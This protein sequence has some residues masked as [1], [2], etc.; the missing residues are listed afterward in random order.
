MGKNIAYGA[1]FGVFWGIIEGI[2][3]TLLHRIHLPFTGEILAS[4]AILI[5]TFAYLKS[6]KKEVV[7]IAG[8]IA[9][10]TKL[11]FMGNIF[12]GPIIG[13]GIISI[14][15]YTG[16]FTFPGKRGIYFAGLLAGSWSPFYF[17]IIKLK[18]IGPELLTLYEKFF[19]KMGIE[20]KPLP[21]IITIF[22]I[23]WILSIIGVLGAVWLEKEIV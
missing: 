9:I 3:G 14:L 5:M 22:I 21:L 16:I 7:I 12:I 1:V 15:F 19:Y 8:I 6:S 17:G 23:G 2:F 4:I 11:T 10:I 13:I 18:I 20:I